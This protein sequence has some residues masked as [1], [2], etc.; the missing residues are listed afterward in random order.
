M[1]KRIKTVFS[2]AQTAHVWAQQTQPYGHS[3]NMF[4]RENKIYSYGEHYLAAVIHKVKGK[5]I[6]LVRSDTYSNSTSKHLSDICRAVD[7]LMPYYRVKNVDN[8]KKASREL[9]ELA[10]NRLSLPLKR[11]KVT[12][13][14]EAKWEFERIEDAFQDANALRALLGKVRISP[15]QVDLDAVKDHLDKRLKRYKELNTP[16]A[17]AKREVK[18]AKKAMLKK[19]TNI[20]KFRNGV[21]PRVYGLP[22]D[23]LRVDGDIIKTSS[24]AEVPLKAGLML[25]AA[26]LKGKSIKGKIIGHFTAETV[27]KTPDGDKIVKI[28]CHKILLSE[29]KAVLE[30]VA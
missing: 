20:T 12:F 19:E 4:F 3:K 28:G 11:M 9:D 10:Y 21:S 30:K 23:L 5:R 7:S 17:I 1:T 14:D 18:A 25:L 26:V 6:A 24:G 29:A 27:T 13:V 15:K 2:N 16:A 8:L 22:F